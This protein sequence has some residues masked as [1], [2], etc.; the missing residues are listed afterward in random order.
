MSK[1]LTF[2]HKVIFIMYCFPCG[3]QYMD[4]N[5]IFNIPNYLYKPMYMSSTVWCIIF[6]TIFS[7]ENIKCATLFQ[8]TKILNLN[9]FI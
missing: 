7:C 6:S 9:I 4:L 1:I 5:L 2:L 3:E 8:K